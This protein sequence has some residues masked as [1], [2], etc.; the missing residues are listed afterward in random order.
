MLRKFCLYGFLKN[1]RYFEPFII[2]YFL[3]RGL[4]FTQIGFL[5]AF[6][7]IV[8]N[9]AEIPSGALA[10]LYGRRRSMILSFSAYIVSFLLF[11]LCRQ[12]WHFFIAMIFFA[13]GEAFRT[14]THKALI[15]SWLRRQGRLDE[16]NEVYGY[17]R[18]WSKLGSAASIIVA[19]LLVF[20]MKNYSAVF[21]F[22]IFPYVLGLINFMTYPKD[23]DH[24]VTSIKMQ[25]VFLHLW[26]ALK[27]AFG[28]YSL[29]RLIYESMAFEG[30][31][32]IVKDYLQPVL[33]NMV[34]F[35]PLLARLGD[36]QKSAVIV[37][38]VYFVLNLA[39]AYASR[40][41]YKVSR[42]SGGEEKAARLLWKIALGLY[43]LLTPLL[44]SK[45][46]YLVV[47][48][49]I[50]LYL[51]QNFWRPL[52]ISRFFA[53]AE[54]KEGA[55]ILSIESQAKTFAAMVTAPVLGIMVD[56]VKAHGFGGEFWP[57]GA[58]GFIVALAILL[59]Q[60]SLKTAGKS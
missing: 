9:L 56:F 19:T 33:K 26:A 52:L 34:L 11:G 53:R 29:R 42:F 6:R 15:F 54:D 46:Y 55:T 49:F 17:T 12:Y 58:A 31:F 57:V 1:Q 10:D 43:L 22:T 8:I 35:I 48:M 27:N 7:E 47:V 18:S 24:S 21:Y 39:S 4:T 40:E 23:L 25:D 36:K 28:N 37:G 60:P 41:S 38:S 2:L 50:A 32:K 5:I 45:Y 13:F 59:T 51:L 30:I 20:F 3:D 44:F 14:G 16:R